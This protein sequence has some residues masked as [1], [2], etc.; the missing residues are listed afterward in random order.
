MILFIFKSQIN[1]ILN[2][3]KV[4]VVAI[5]NRKNILTLKVFNLFNICIHIFITKTTAIMM[6]NF[7]LIIFLII[8]TF[9]EINLLHKKKFWS[10]YI[11]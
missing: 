7:M 6:F 11:L 8:L 9:K 5:V 4:Q 2:L 3:N 10:A 1:I